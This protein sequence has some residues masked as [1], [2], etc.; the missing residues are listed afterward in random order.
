MKEP[1]IRNFPVEPQA[2][3]AKTPGKKAQP[4]GSG[5]RSAKLNPLL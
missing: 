2:R 3:A 1:G 5:V 4:N